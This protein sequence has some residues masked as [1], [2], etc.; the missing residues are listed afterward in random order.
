MLANMFDE[1]ALDF[2]SP[3]SYINPSYITLNQKYDYP[4]LI[5]LIVAVILLTLLGFW[6]YQT[7]DIHSA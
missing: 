1:R 3:M 7:K 5:C 6:R 4:L 2:I